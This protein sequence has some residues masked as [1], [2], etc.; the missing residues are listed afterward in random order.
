MGALPRWFFKL[1]SMKCILRLIVLTTP[2]RHREH[3]FLVFLPKGAY[4]GKF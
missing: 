3:N 1:G 2:S 4:I